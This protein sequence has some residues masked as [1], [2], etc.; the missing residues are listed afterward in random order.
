[1][2]NNPYMNSTPDPALTYRDSYQPPKYEPRDPRDDDR[3]RCRVCDVPMVRLW[4]FINVDG[5]QRDHADPKFL[6][7]DF[8]S[9]RCLKRRLYGLPDDNEKAMDVLLR[10]AEDAEAEAKEAQVLAD[11]H[12][13]HLETVRGALASLLEVAPGLARGAVPPP[14]QV[15]ARHVAA[16]QKL[17][18]MRV[19]ADDAARRRHRRAG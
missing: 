3:R 9:I 17:V 19:V 16:L 11:A 2:S 5:T 18:G 7:D 8:C 13:S 10:R 15:L 1:M 14:G 12:V 6:N 4:F